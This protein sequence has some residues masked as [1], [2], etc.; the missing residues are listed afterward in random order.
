M[1]IF[2]EDVRTSC[3]IRH[4]GQRTNWYNRL[5][6]WLLGDFGGNR[7]EPE[8]SWAKVF[9]SLVRTLRACGQSTKQA[10]REDWQS[11]RS[12]DFTKLR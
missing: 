3:F 1:A 6:H 8:K 5:G 11:L 4:S 9:Q 2:S 12:D 7:P 10:M